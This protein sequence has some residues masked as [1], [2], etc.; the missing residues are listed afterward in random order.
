VLAVCPSTPDLVWTSPGLLQADSHLLEP[1]MC[2]VYS[3]VAGEEVNSFK[4]A[5]HN[6]ASWCTSLK[7]MLE[8]LGIV[9]SE[10]PQPIDGALVCR[11]IN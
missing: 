8:P 7:A 9:I 2:N 1:S 10:N 5:S 6:K 11:L 4:L 3:Q